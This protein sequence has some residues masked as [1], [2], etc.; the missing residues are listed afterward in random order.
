MQAASVNAD[1]RRLSEELQATKDYC[2]KVES[3][4]VY[5][6][7]GQVDASL[8]RAC[9]VSRRSPSA[10]TC[11]PPQYLLEQTVKLKDSVRLLRAENEE[12][13]AVRGDLESRLKK[14]ESDV[15]TLSK[16][17]EI[18]TESL[19]LGRPMDIRTSLLYEV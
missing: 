2:K 16:A 9:W 13:A 3:K 12:Y 15:H 4:L 7:N 5:G 1:N 14:A 18:R 6:S 10:H 11:A 17:L 19:G 8:R